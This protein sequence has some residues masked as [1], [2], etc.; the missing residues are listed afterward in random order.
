MPENREYVSK[1][2]EKG[3]VNISEEVI[4]II[5]STAA[6]ETEGVAGFSTTLGKEISELFGGKK[7]TSRGTKISI[8]DDTVTVDTYILIKYGYSISD[9]AKAVQEA[10][11]GAVESMTGLKTAAVNVHVCGVSFSKER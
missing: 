7:N 6:S 5:A 9:T 2:E 11:S 1:I 10:V 3:S 4:A 8:E